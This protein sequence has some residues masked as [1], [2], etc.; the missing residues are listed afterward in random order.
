VSSYLTEL[1]AVCDRIGVILV[2]P[3]FDLKTPEYVAAQTAAEVVR[4]YPSVG[5]TREI[6]DYF[7][8]FDVNIDALV[9][10]LERHR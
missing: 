1:L 4:L 10:A 9:A 8:L 7:D 6:A 3:Y 5:G 2:E